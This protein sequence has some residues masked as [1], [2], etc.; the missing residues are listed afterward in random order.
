MGVDEAYVI[1]IPVDVGFM[2]L[3]LPLSL[4]EG[5]YRIARRRCGIFIIYKLL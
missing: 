2:L 5:W 1:N 4:M 3:Y